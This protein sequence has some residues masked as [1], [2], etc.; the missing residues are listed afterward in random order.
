MK[1]MTDQPDDF[2]SEEILFDIAEAADGRPPKVTPEKGLR[3]MRERLEG[4]E[5]QVN[6]IPPD[7]RLTEL[8]KEIRDT[9]QRIA[10]YETQLK[11]QN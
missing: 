4:L 7:A 11:G 3:L 10:E 9:K 8:Y 2:I 5:R 6:T 1:L